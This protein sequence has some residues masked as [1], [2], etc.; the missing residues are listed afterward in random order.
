MSI[1]SITLFWI[2]IAPSWYGL[3]YAL[4]F[5][6]GYFI[7]RSRKWLPEAE[8]E[9][10]VTYVFLGVLLGGRFWYV[11]FYNLPHYLAHPIEILQ[12]WQGGMS[13]HGWV[14]GVIIAMMF[15]AHNHKKPFLVIA[16]HV[17]SILPIG[18]WLGRI[19]NY[20]NKE[21]L[22]FTPYTG[23]FAVMKDGLSYFPS[24]LLEAG[25]EGIIL[26]IILYFLGK[27]NIFPGKTATSFLIWYWLFR[28][29]I[30][31]IRTPDVWLGYLSM[32]LTMG[33]IL[34]IPMVIIGIILYFLFKT[35]CNIKVSPTSL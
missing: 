15:F 22:G 14:I 1:F 21:L 6:V 11:L 35:K 30:E 32:G 34:S 19:G 27:K 5:M 7:I 12:T 4:G 23:P 10:L 33:Q 9:S 3:M 2:H 25:L 8:L 18:L 17:T 13:F 31:F 16:D 29:S 24:P 28:F 26:F 20:L